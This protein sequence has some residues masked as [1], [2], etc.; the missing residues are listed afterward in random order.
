MAITFRIEDV[1]T[2]EGVARA[3][4]DLERV[5]IAAE[6]IAA[7]ASVPAR[8]PEDPV[9]EPPAPVGEASDPVDPVAAALS[10]AEKEAEEKV[11]LRH[12]EFV[13][14][15]RMTK[16]WPLLSAAHKLQSKQKGYFSIEE[17]A[18]TAGHKKGTAYGYKDDIGFKA[19]KYGISRTFY[20]T[21]LN[22]WR[23][24][25]ALHEAM[26]RHV[27]DREAKLKAKRESSASGAA[28]PTG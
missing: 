11:V 9:T 7:G 26:G 19:Q 5:R 28:Q 25:P 6:S 10:A 1:L 18:R 17:L 8:P 23:M 21:M 15:L 12:L 2:P 24:T 3:T 4:L 20:R 16:Y 13:R 22:C 14:S 27:A